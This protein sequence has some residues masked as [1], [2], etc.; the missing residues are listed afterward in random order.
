MD[1]FHGDLEPIKC[2]HFRDLYLVHELLREVLQDYP[3]TGREESKYILNKML[4]ILSKFDPI[5][6]VGSQVQFLGCPEA[7]YLFF[8]HVPYVLILYREHYVSLRVFLKEGLCYL[9]LFDLHCGF[10]R[11]HF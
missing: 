6:H 2:A 10:G 11:I 9:F 5:N 1:I 3:V 7:C 8:V 4:F